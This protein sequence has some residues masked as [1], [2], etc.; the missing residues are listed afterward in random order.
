[1]LVEYKK[2]VFNGDTETE[3]DSVYWWIESNLRN[4]SIESQ[5]QKLRNLMVVVAEQWLSENQQRVAEVAT[6]IECSG[7]KHKITHSETSH[8]AE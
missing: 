5:I 8:G 7:Y 6:A 3:H 4:G 2:S 1:M